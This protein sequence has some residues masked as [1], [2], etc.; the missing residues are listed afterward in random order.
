MRLVAANG[1]QFNFL[2]NTSSPAE[3][4]DTIGGT[5]VE[6]HWSRHLLNGSA[7]MSCDF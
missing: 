2:L 1:G 3:P 4:L 6:K 7:Y 5:P